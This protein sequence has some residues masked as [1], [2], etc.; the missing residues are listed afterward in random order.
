M[1]G[2]NDVTLIFRGELS[3]ET[4]V[5]NLEA[6]AAKGAVFQV[7]IEAGTPSDGEFDEWDA[8]GT[9]SCGVLEVEADV[10]GLGD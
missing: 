5:N 8:L 10:F 2:T 1:E 6:M 9:I 7:D 4:T 3:M